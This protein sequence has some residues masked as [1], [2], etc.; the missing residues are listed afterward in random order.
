MSIHRHRRKPYNCHLG[1]HS[2][3]DFA[4]P[5]AGTVLCLNMSANAVRVFTQLRVQMLN[6]LLGNP[7]DR[8]LFAID[9]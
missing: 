4:P 7:F 9:T 6:G 3:P 8:I 2:L 5:G 1:E